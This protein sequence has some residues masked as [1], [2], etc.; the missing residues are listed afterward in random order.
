M[1]VICTERTHLNHNVTARQ[2]RCKVLS[3]DL[4]TPINIFAISAFSQI[5]WNHQMLSKMVIHYC[6]S[7]MNADINFFVV[8]CT[9]I[10]HI[11]KLI[12][13]LQSIYFVV[14]FFPWNKF[15]FANT[16]IRHIPSRNFYG[17]CKNYIKSR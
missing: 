3:M 12:F 17:K 8:L 7:S 10:E 2:L 6:Q 5:L 1:Y 13:P 15:Y 11:C 4:K 9:P 14:M 16:K